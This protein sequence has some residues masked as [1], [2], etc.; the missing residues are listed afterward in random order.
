M[1][2]TAT[3]KKVQELQ[4]RF[5]AP[6]QILEG[7]QYRLLGGQ[8]REELAEGHE[9]AAFVLFWFAS[10]R[11]G[12]ARGVVQQSREQ[13]SQFAC[14]WLRVDRREGEQVEQRGIGRGEIGGE[15]GTLEDE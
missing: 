2:S 14:Q 6:M 4:A 5:V 8:A 13:R 9:Q 15:A 12:F 1:S 11:N 10:R 3:R 7:E